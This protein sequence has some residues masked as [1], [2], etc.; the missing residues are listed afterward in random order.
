MGDDQDQIFKFG[1]NPVKVL[2]GGKIITTSNCY[3][4]P[5][6]KGGV[7]SDIIYPHR[8]TKPI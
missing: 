2:C 6:P 4:I 3:Q 8:L 5:P 7:H 1:M